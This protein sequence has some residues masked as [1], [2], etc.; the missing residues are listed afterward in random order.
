MKC[1]KNLNLARDK[2]I[3]ASNVFTSSIA[4]YEIIVY[5]LIERYGENPT[6]IALINS[7]LR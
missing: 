3:Y 7:I 6:N 4:P 1:V 2:S 5:L